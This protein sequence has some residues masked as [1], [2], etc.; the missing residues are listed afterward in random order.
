M[1]HPSDRIAWLSVLRAP[2]CGLSRADLLM[3][4]GEGQTADPDATIVELVTERATLLS[5]EG[6]RLLARAWPVLMAATSTLGRTP[7]SVHVERT[8]RSLGGDAPLSSADR[9]N[10]ER[11]LEVLH[12]AE[13]E[14]GLIDLGHLKTRLRTLFAEPTSTNAQ[15]ELL[16]IHRA[17]GLEWDFVL[18]PGLERSPRGTTDTLLNWIEIDGLTPEEDS[19]ILLAP[20]SGKGQASSDLHQWLRKIRGGRERAETK[21]L[22][23]V[24]AT[25]AR[26]ELHLFAALKLKDSG[27]LALPLP[28]TLLHAAWPAA[29]PHFAERLNALDMAESGGSDESSSPNAA[30]LTWPG[31]GNTDMEEEE[32]LAIAAGAE[33]SSE[34]NE[35]VRSEADSTPPVLERLPLRFDPQ[36][37]FRV[38]P[39]ERLDYPSAAMLRHAPSF[40]RPE[41]S[42]AARAF[43]NVVH[44]YLQLLSTRIAAGVSGGSLADELSAWQPRLET[45]LRG[46]GI[47]PALASREAARALHALRTTVQDPAGQWVLAAHNG[48]STERALQLPLGSL[49]ADRTFFASEAPLS[50]GDGCLWIIDFKTTEPGSRDPER[51]RAAEVARYSPQLEAYADLLR[52]LHGRAIPIRLGLYFPLIPQLLHWPSIATE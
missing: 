6:Q 40:D 13:G 47:A 1:L 15:V 9:T 22:F 50:T 38:R 31:G 3:L 36:A 52:S 39:T 42:F 45:S 19:S 24:A 7:L 5:D 32:S 29:Q 10:V 33:N 44:R 14:T 27:E 30:A 43:G 16:T 49:R 18:L 26:E 2:W 4:T 20:I 23:Y 37:R 46:E 48:A 21:R 25:R 11:Y 28:S 41:G 35:P 12:E 17:K 51:F 34:S 8:W